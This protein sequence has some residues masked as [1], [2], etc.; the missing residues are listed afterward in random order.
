MSDPVANGREALDQW[1]GYPWYDAQTDGVRR[2]EVSAPWNENW[3]ISIDLSGPLLQYLAWGAI[4][5]I[6]V[7]AVFLLI[8]A[9]WLG[10]FDSQEEE[11]E[12]TG[13]ADRIEALP[14]PLP[15]GRVDLLAEARRCYDEGNF[16]QAIIYFFSYQLIQLDRHEIVHLARGK[17]NRQY[18]RE[19]SRRSELVGLFEQTMMTF[20]ETYFGHRELDRIRFETCWARLDEFETLV[21]GAMA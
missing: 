10:E 1:Y 15:R 2:V 8:R 3:D 16:A 12:P 11:P 9:Y 5:L 14:V 17:T 4:V 7:V 21:Q 20:E 13:S 19:V 6:L 18:L